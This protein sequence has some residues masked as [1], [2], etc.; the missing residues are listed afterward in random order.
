MKLLSNVS[1]KL[2]L[3][4]SGGNIFFRRYHHYIKRIQRGQ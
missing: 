3:R 1:L 2:Q 4:A